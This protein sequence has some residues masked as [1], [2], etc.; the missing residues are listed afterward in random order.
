[1][2]RE[3][4]RKNYSRDFESQDTYDTRQVGFN[5]NDSFS[6]FLTQN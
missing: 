2:D 4:L 6:L 5:M 3:D 1:M